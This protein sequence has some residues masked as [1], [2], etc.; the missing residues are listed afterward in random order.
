MWKAAGGRGRSASG[1]ICTLR[2]YTEWIDSTTAALKGPPHNRSAP[3]Q[4]ASFRQRLQVPISLQE[5]ALARVLGD[6]TP[7][8]EHVLG[9]GRQLEG[10]AGP[11]DDVR[12]LSDVK[13]SDAIGHA[14]ELRGYERHGLQGRVAI[15]PV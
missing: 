1:L 10:I 9:A 11:D 13:R 3:A 15:Q 8:N 5:L 7:A 14:P 2:V 6:F 12:V 4:G